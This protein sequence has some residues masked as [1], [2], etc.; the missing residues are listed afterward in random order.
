MEITNN[1]KKEQHKDSDNKIKISGSIGM[2]KLKND[3]KNIYIF[4]DDHSNVNYCDKNDSIFLYDMIDNFINLN[5]DYVIL[6]EEPFISNY[7]NIKFL[8][9]ETPHIIKFRKFYKK[10][11]KK[12]SDTKSCY[13]YPVDIRLIICDLSM[14]EIL[15]NLENEQ[16][17]L[18]YN[19]TL[20]QYFKYILFLF[21][22][23]EYDEEFFKDCDSNIKFVKKVF[24]EF[25]ESRYYKN[26]KNQFEDFYLKFIKTNKSIKIRD[27]LKINS[28][29]SYSF[30]TGFP[31]ENNN[32][33]DFLDMYDKIINGIMEFYTFILIMGIRT[34][35]ILLYSGYYHSNNLSYILEKYYDFKK[36]FSIG[37][38]E[39]IETKDERLI[40]NCLLID[41]K[42]FMDY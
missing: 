35:N 28:D 13:V 12:C 20:F 42:V 6:L 31:F 25:T 41:K 38:T 33:K 30:Y 4:Y 3:K 11:I 7:S 29:G 27:F 10:V 19:P 15:I 18:D 14:D 1:N 9:N 16:Y 23:I 24:C 34:K 17:F 22:Y 26:L 40:K 37:N 32:N 8:W 2:V 39:N 5:Q 36:I 21:D